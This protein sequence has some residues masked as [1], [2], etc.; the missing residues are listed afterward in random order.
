MAEQLMDAMSQV[1]GDPETYRGMKAG[2][3]A[4]AIPAGS[5][6]YFLTTFGRPMF[7]EVICE[8]DEQPAM[9]QTM[10]LIA[11]DTLHKK[12]TAQKGALS[13]MIEDPYLKD[14]DVARR[15]FF[16]ALVRSPEKAELEKALAPVKEKGKEGRRRAFE[17]LL[18]ALFNSKE[19]LYNH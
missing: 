8:R 17:D 18:W 7:R 2:A 3:K 13:R 19:F 5:P 1:A 14:E 15:L 6:N 4:M 10:H 11:G 9:A 16:A 12:L